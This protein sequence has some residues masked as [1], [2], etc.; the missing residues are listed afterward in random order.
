M[1]EKHSDEDAMPAIPLEYYQRQ[2]GH[3]AIV[4]KWAAW[5]GIAYGLTTIAAAMPVIL[6]YLMPNLGVGSRIILVNFTMVVMVVPVVAAAGVLLGGSVALLRG[7]KA[8]RLL[9]IWSCAALILSAA[10]QFVFYAG[11]HSWFSGNLGPSLGSS[12][13]VYQ[14]I[15]QFFTM[16][17]SAFVPTMLILLFRQRQMREAMDG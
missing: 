13:Y 15:S 8:G 4:V 5:V 2:I 9:L 7:N 12:F 17:R 16:V 10:I 14:G 3:W 1:G 11:T 6:Y